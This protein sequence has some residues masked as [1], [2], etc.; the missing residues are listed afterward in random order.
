VVV[1]I[2]TTA[3]RHPYCRWKT[4]LVATQV[5]ANMLDDIL[6]RDQLH[7]LGLFAH[8]LL[9]LGKKNIAPPHHHYRRVCVR[10]LLQRN[11]GVCHMTSYSI[12]NRRNIINWT[13]LNI[14][15]PVHS[16]S[17][18][19]PFP[20]SISTKFRHC[21]KLGTHVPDLRCQQRYARLVHTVQ[22]LEFPLK[23]A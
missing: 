1:N 18:S 17:I 8:I 12:I 9:Q 22:F 19:R 7:E 21:G 13:T 10:R 5:L 6:P 14:T 2:Q 11:I 4:S 16:L 15:W 3:A 20:S 23:S